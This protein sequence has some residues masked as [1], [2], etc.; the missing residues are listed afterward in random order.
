[1]SVSQLGE[2]IVTNAL[3]SAGLNPKPSSRNGRL[4]IFSKN[5]TPKD[6]ENSSQK[7]E[8][9]KEILVNKI[10]R[11]TTLAL[12]NLI[13]NEANENEEEEE[14]EEESPEIKNELLENN[15]DLMEESIKKSLDIEFSNMLMKEK[16]QLEA[17]LS[18]EDSQDVSIISSQK[19]LEA[20][21]ERNKKIDMNLLKSKR[22]TIN[23]RLAF[24]APCIILINLSSF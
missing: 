8:D 6:S 22:R 11:Q 24:L 9:L 4:S 10:T 1:M 2:A 19:L 18:D 3:K 13:E 21:K 20:Q 5:L 17:S 16:E 12:K 23:M 15:M 14:E 7:P